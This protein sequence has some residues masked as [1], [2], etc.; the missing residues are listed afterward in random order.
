MEVS[1]HHYIQWIGTVLSDCVYVFVN[2]HPIE[3]EWSFYV[4]HL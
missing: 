2:A 3:I 1:G 4:L